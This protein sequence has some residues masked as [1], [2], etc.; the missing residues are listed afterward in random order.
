MQPIKRG[1][2]QIVFWLLGFT[3]VG[4][5]QLVPVYER[6][7]GENVI[8]EREVGGYNEV[9]NKFFVTADLVSSPEQFSEAI[10][11]FQKSDVYLA[12]SS[13]IEKLILD[14]TYTAVRVQLKNDRYF[15]IT[16]SNQGNDITILE[17]GIIG[18]AR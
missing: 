13:A 4:C 5:S 6:T 12:E 15:V 14:T 16:K 1:S 9:E 10:A 3:L 18:R 11:L 17:S 7:Y 8:I 2:F